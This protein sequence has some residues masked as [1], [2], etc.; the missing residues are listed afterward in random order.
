MQNTAQ[1]TTSHLERK[2][3]DLVKRREALIDSFSKAAVQIK[4]QRL[5]TM[6]K[7]ICQTNE[8]LQSLDQIETE[9]KPVLDSKSRRYVVSSLFLHES[10]KKLTAD[11]NEQFFFVTG[12]EVDG[13]LVLDQ[14]VEFA[15]QS[16]TMMGVV[17]EPS[18]THKLLIKLEQFGQR[19][20]GHFHSHP[21]TGPDATHPSGTD[22]HFQ[23]RLEGGGSVAVA[24][25]FSRDG[26][27]RFFR[28]DEDLE[29]EI[30]GVGVE[31]HEPNIYRLR[32]LDAA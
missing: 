1:P 7:R 23:R 13:V 32:N 22:E 29:I 16:R 27:I 21:G 11:Q 3:E 20:L 17:A 31:K 5:S 15:H 19:L 18:S 6:Y 9:T 25:I 26:Y 2:R 28:L 8:F 4:P 14:V 30:H 10:F 12:S 24:A